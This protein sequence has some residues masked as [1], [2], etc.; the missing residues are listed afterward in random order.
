MNPAT[1]VRAVADC[2]MLLIGMWVDS[3]IEVM[4]QFRLILG[5]NPLCSR[6]Y[7]LLSDRGEIQTCPPLPRQ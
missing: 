2:R 7:W 3:F 1:S 5:S 6:F 4:Q